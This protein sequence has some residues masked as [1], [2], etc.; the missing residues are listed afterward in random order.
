MKMKVERISLVKELK[1]LARRKPTHMTADRIAEWALSCLASGASVE[2][3]RPEPQ[4][5]W[6]PFITRLHALEDLRV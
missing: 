4:G 2:V 1:L 3:T 6:L 5:G